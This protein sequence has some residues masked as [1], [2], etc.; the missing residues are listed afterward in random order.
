MSN[1]YWF[2]HKFE[3][4]TMKRVLLLQKSKDKKDAK[5]DDI[6]KSFRKLGVTACQSLQSKKVN[7]VQFLISSKVADKETLGIFENSFYLS[8]YENSLKRPY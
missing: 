8:N 1:A 6:K 4:Q 2:Y 7:D 5:P 3:D